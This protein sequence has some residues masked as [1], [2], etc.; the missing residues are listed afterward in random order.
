VVVILE[1][2]SEPITTIEA[3]LL[4]DGV[5]NDVLNQEFKFS[6]AKFLTTFPDILSAGDVYNW[7]TGPLSTLIFSSQENFDTSS[8]GN[9][10]PTLMPPTH[11]EAGKTLVL[12]CMIRQVRSARTLC[13]NSQLHFC[14]NKFSTASEN[15]TAR[16]RAN[17]LT[18]E[19]F[20]PHEYPNALHNIVNPVQYSSG[21]RGEQLMPAEGGMVHTHEF[22]DGTVADT[23]GWY[24]P[25]YYNASMFASD[26]A[27]MQANRW[28]D[29]YTAMLAVTCSAMNAN[30]DLVLRVRYTIEFTV[31]GK[32][33]PRA[34]YTMIGKLN[35]EKGKDYDILA[36]SR[37]ISIFLIFSFHGIGSLVVI[38]NRRGFGNIRN[39]W[40]MLVIHLL[41]CLS[42]MVVW[43][44]KA[45]A[46]YYWPKSLSTTGA[47]IVTSFARL[48][49]VIDDRLSANHEGNEY[50]YFVS[51]TGYMLRQSQI[52]MGLTEF[53]IMLGLL[54]WV[55][56][57]PHL[58]LFGRTLWR[59][60]LPCTMFFII[61]FTLLLG[62]AA[63]FQI[64][65][66]KLYFRTLQIS[67]FTLF[68][69]MLG[70]FPIDEMTYFEPVLAPLLYIIYLTVMLFTAFTI[71]IAIISSAH[72][73]VNEEIEV[74]AANVLA[75]SKS[76]A[77]YAEQALDPWLNTAEPLFQ[78]MALMHAQQQ[79]AME[80]L[81]AHQSTAMLAQQH[82]QQQALLDLTRQSS[83]DTSTTRQSSEDTELRRVYTDMN[84]LQLSDLAQAE[85]GLELT[86]ADSCVPGPQNVF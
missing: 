81:H 31:E 26:V 76:F 39:Y 21:E 48:S 68:R 27:S 29:Q 32:V 6:D 12:G 19:R 15:K 4:N 35:A 14:V 38:A 82:A 75:K 36:Y 40:S 83:E 80:L 53:F 59:S 61:F 71:L 16:L 62:F 51:S 84:M 55:D 54:C 73:Q 17:G 69:G 11:T 24:D 3:H 58:N 2:A 63:L 25:V 86:R 56:N 7:F 5:V 18:M 1:I 46:L 65:F 50:S 8:P 77:Q 52:F 79:A 78:A 28:I 45:V 13:S 20:V 41:S 33:R 44:L 64:I 85:M 67:L 23:G 60:A 70:D 42:G 22:L 10:L 57:I 34:P 43:L 47:E 66:S 37:Q 72:Q 49:E 74:E 9:T 30:S